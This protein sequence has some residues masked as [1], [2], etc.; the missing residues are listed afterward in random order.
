MDSSLLPTSI[1]FCSFLLHFQV[2]ATTPSC[3]TRC[4]FLVL[5][6]DQDPTVQQPSSSSAF[7]APAAASAA[8]APFLSFCSPPMRSCSCPSPLRR[9][10]SHLVLRLGPIPGPLPPASQLAAIPQPRR[11]LTLGD[12]R[13]NRLT[14]RKISSASTI[15]NTET[16][17]GCDDVVSILHNFGFSGR[18]GSSCKSAG[19]EISAAWILNS[20]ISKPSQTTLQR[21]QKVGSDGYGDVYRVWSTNHFINIFICISHI[22]NQDMYHESMSS[23]LFYQA[24]HQG[25]E[26]AVK[27][28]HQL[29]GLD[30]K[31]F[32][33]EYRNLR[34]VRHKNVVW[35]IGY[36]DETRSKYMNH[37]GELVFSKIIERVLCF[38]YMQGGGLDKHITGN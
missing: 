8:T 7:L 10:R 15:A 9:R 22:Y 19:Y 32:H 26:I 3:L 23:C 12:S 30:D 37:N 17:Y 1:A 21:D 31:Q 20:R 18:R 16:I 28:L 4:I 29:H 25:E 6:S 27:K 24:T 34:Q 35:L 2:S 13:G 33:A 14:R 36:C 38:E 5:P 11:R